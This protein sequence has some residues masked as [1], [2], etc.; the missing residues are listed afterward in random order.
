MCY[1]KYKNLHNFGTKTSEWKHTKIA[2]DDM[3]MIRDI[4]NSSI[5][6][7][8]FTKQLTSNN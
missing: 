5:Q 2:A 7:N 4:L 3:K 6:L 1:Y 8:K